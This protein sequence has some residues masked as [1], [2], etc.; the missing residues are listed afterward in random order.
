MGLRLHFMERL[1]ADLMLKW[2]SIWVIRLHSAHDA[3]LMFDV[4]MQQ[5]PCLHRQ[6]AISLRIFKT[7]I[8]LKRHMLMCLPA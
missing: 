8:P 4:E 6:T 2:F 5:G 7:C 3:V 1:Q